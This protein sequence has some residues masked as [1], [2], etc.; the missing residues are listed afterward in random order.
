MREPYQIAI[1]GPSGRGKTSSF[2]NMN[3]ETTG[4]I[5]LENKPLP[6]KNKFRHYCKPSTW[7]EAYTKLIEYAKNPEI[8][9]VVL[10][11]FS[12]YIDSLLKTARDIKKNYDVWNMYNEEIGKLMT[13]IVK[14]YPK[15]LFI[16]GHV[17]NVET[18]TGVLERRMAVKGNEWN[19]IGVEKDF[20][21]VMF[22]DVKIIDNNTRD[23]ILVLNSDGTTSAKTPQIF[24]EGKTSI[25]NDCNIIIEEL[26][27]VLNEE[28][29]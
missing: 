21:I 11:S 1:I 25:P 26:N 19:K 4:F 8:K 20:T 12:E 15:D 6:F 27:K 5:N 7:Q 2:R 29:K 9:V 10:E 22:A 18:E 24:F 16:T 23:Y 28:N 17:A 3:P 13:N 14:K